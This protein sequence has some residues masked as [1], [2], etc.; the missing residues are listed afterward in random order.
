MWSAMD[1]VQSENLQTRERDAH[2]CQLDDCA[3]NNNDDD[4]NNNNNSNAILTLMEVSGQLTSTAVF[5]QQWCAMA[6]DTQHAQ[7]DLTIEKVF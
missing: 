2:M 7:R 5:Q 3:N 1:N 4:D 6:N